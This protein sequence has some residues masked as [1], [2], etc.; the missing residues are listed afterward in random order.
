MSYLL[1]TLTHQKQIESEEQKMNEYLYE[2]TKDLSDEEFMWVV[3]NN[4]L[5]TNRRKN[6][7]K[8]NEYHGEE[9]NYDFYC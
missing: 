3:H 1:P 5:H 9:S 4:K 6:Y 8:E 2:M 7:Q